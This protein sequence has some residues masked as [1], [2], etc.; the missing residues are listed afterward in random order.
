MLE[1]DGGL[2]MKVAHGRERKGSVTNQQGVWT[3]QRST[4]AQID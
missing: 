1:A 2:S 4:A 3:W